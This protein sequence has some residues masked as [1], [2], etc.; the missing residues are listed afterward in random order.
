MRAIWI[1]CIGC[2]SAVAT[3]LLLARVHPFGD[4]G[5]DAGLVASLDAGKTAQAAI[6]TAIMEHSSVPTEVRAALAAKCADCHSMQVRAPLYGRFAPISWL[7]ERDIVEG[8]KKMN[9]SQWNSYS[10]DQQQTLEAKIVQQTK[11]HAM[12]PLPYRMIHWNA[13]ITDAD[14][15]SFTEWTREAPREAGSEAQGEG[16]PIRGKEIFAKRCTGCHAMEQNREGP[17]LQGV[18]GRT[19]GVVPGFGYSVALKQAHIV[20]NDTSLEH[21]LA[22]PDTLVPGNNMEF[23]VAKSQERRDLIALLKQGVA[24]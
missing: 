22:D 11:A 13:R 6:Q 5:L 2:A 15:R 1:A 19:S 9:L 7:M 3:S 12:P 24:K 18:Y 10:T 8:R 21:W 20:W 17:R 14:V 4:A 16:S 23:H